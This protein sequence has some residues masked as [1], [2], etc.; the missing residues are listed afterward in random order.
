M[1]QCKL[2]LHAR[3]L[4]IL[5]LLVMGI[6]VRARAANPC[7]ISVLPKE[8]QTTL[9]KSYPDWKPERLENLSQYYRR[10]WL[11]DHP[12]DCPGIA[13]GHF[14]SK[15]ELSYALFLVPGPDRKQPGASIVVFSRTGPTIPFVSHLVFKWDVGNFYGHSDLVI[16]KIAAGRY[17][18][19]Q[20]L[21][22]LDGVLYEAMEK[23]SSLYYWKNGQYHGLSV[24]D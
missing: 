20:V 21:I 13:I 11:K 23:A 7:D 19:P 16:S 18:D 24:S 5:G 4:T 22:D 15:S 3:H 10:F 17:G 6:C 9:E 14:E 2:L 12:N 8:I 1:G